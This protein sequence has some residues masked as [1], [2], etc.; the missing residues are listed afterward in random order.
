MADRYPIQEE[1]HV[2]YQQMAFVGTDL[3]KLRVD[4]SSTASGLLAKISGRSSTL[5]STGSR[6][7]PELHTTAGSRFGTRRVACGICIAPSPC[8]KA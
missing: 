5:G 1:E 7:V 2:Q 6:L 4:T 8:Q 3:L